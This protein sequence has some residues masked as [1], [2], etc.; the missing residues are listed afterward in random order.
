MCGFSFVYNS[1][2][3]KDELRHKVLS[4]ISLLEARGPDC[5]GF[6]YQGSAFFGHRRLSIIDVESSFQPFSDPQRRFF[7]VYNG[8]IYN[9][10]ELRAQLKDF[11]DFQTS[12]DTEVLLAGLVV[13]G[14][15][16]LNQLRGMWSFVFWDSF[17]NL[18]IAARDVF[19][20]KP[21]F[22][23]DDDGISEGSFVA[24]SE[25]RS[26]IALLGKSSDLSV[27]LDSLSD[28]FRF[29][30]CQPGHTFYSKIKEVLPGHFVSWKPG[31]PLRQIKYW[32]PANTA[33]DTSKE[34]LYE[35]FKIAV[36][37]RLVADV[38]VG[39]F[40]SGGIDSA[41]VAAFAKKSKDIRTFSLGFGSGTF[42]ESSDAIK[43]ASFLGTDHENFRFQDQGLRSV[44]EAQNRRMGQPYADSS[45]MPMNQ[46]CSGASRYGKVFL[47][48]DGADELFG[49]YQRYVGGRISQL[50]D[51]LPPFIRNSVRRF[52][53]HFPEPHDHH[54][55]S[56]LKKV[57]LFLL[58]NEF[59]NKNYIAPL[60][61]SSCMVK[62]LV[63]EASFRDSRQI[64][65][66][67]WVGSDDV[68][69]EMMHKDVNLYLP[70][71]ILRKVDAASMNNSVEV[72]CPFLDIDLFELSLGYQ[73]SDLLGIG[74]N[75]KR[76]FKDSF[77]GE[78]PDF[79]WKKPKHGF[80]SPVA[81]AFRFQGLDLELKELIYSIE[82][83]FINRD[84]VLILLNQHQ[85]GFDH[86]QTLWAVYVFMVWLDGGPMFK[87]G[88]VW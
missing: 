63:S 87:R 29:G 66:P 3:A 72:R 40:L 6:D 79:L 34:E 41:L 26:L 27:E 9:Y 52:F 57:K 64:D 38:P 46:L 73:R 67:D 48:G 51:R 45:F 36:N 24:S 2:I 35:T 20:K 22:Y 53:D 12:G 83:D 60:L 65:W 25:I 88:S 69:L 74:L 10:K 68:A 42:D 54:S 70:Q 11:W 47:S 7:I 85:N 17:E 77:K 32:L 15:E 33:K 30:Y 62:K 13:Y 14:V 1:E 18:L 59:Y 4:S 19:G 39:C 56:A 21:L 43:V 78:I 28:Y 49:G 31:E 5:G 58:F 80:S 82:Q 8:E 44:V 50:Y 86:S 81:G 23:S 37:R 76:N 71:D 84:F 55:H 75:G 16:F 61:S